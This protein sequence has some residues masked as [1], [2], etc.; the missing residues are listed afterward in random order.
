M[1]V[2][3]ACLCNQAGHSGRCRE[4]AEPGLDLLP[5]QPHI[6]AGAVCRGCFEAVRGR[7]FW[8]RASGGRPPQLPPRVASEGTSGGAGRDYEPRRVVRGEACASR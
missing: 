2:L 8:Q 7:D 5:G 6:L 3:C 4:V 1:E